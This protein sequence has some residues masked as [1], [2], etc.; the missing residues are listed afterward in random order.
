MSAHF[1][2][3][4]ELQDRL[5]LEWLQLCRDHAASK[6]QTPDRSVHPPMWMAAH[7][8]CSQLGNDIH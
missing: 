1:T 6:L 2:V 7:H 5:H 3:Q 4:A 8:E